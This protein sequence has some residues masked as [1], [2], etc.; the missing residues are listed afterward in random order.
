MTVTWTLFSLILYFGIA[1][2]FSV[3]IIFILL[4]LSRWLTVW[5]MAMPQ[6]A[7]QSYVMQ[8]VNDTAD[9]SKKMAMYGA[10]NS[11]G[12]IVGPFT[13]SVLLF[14]G[15]LFPMWV[16]VVVLAVF[17]LIIHLRFK[18]SKVVSDSDSASQLNA[19]SNDLKNNDVIRNHV[20]NSYVKNNDLEDKE[21]NQ[22]LK[23]ISHAVALARFDYLY[24]HCHFEY[25]LRLLFTRSFWFNYSTERSVF[26]TKFAHRWCE[27]GGDAIA[28]RQSM[29]IKAS[30]FGDSWCVVYAFRIA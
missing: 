20:Q 16:A 22:N 4:V 10:M 3:L 29:A 2:T 13:T 9:R 19:E 18:E 8:H 14:G 6:I 15:I 5:F 17:S 28:H 25:D 7:L 21:F 12:L 26:F 27:F 24:C 1:Q 30:K 11:L 23:K